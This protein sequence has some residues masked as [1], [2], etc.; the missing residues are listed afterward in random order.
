MPFIRLRMGHPSLHF[1]N[2]CA[3]LKSWMGIQSDKIFYFSASRW[4]HDFSPFNVNAVNCIDWLSN[5]KSY[6]VM[7]LNL[8]CVL[9]FLY[10]AKC[11]L[12]FMQD[13]LHLHSQE[14]LAHNFPFLWNPWQILVAISCCPQKWVGSYSF[15]FILWKSC[16][17]LMGFSFPEIGYIC[18]LSFLFLDQL[19]NVF[20]E[21]AFC[22]INFLCF[23]FL[24]YFIDFWPCFH[25]FLL[26][27][28]K[29]SIL[30]QLLEMKK[31]D[32]QPVFFC[33][34]WISGYGFF[35]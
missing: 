33:D 23:I 9:S 6:I 20:K 5:V 4:S 34:I 29:Y 15:F 25:L 7:N 26:L 22:F 27:L 14:R 3:F 1:Q 28:F 31:A 17:Q 11:H 30:F 18:S 13:F 10:A 35:F 2:F 32:F 8:A 21:W 16:V 12:S 24:F 19:I